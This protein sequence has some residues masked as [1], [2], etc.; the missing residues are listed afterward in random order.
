MVA[1]VPGRIFLSSLVNHSD[2]ISKNILAKTPQ[3]SSAC[4]FIGRIESYAG[5]EKDR[6][7]PPPWQIVIS[8]IF[9]PPAGTVASRCRFNDLTG[10]PTA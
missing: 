6:A 10:K 7:C 3:Q 8:E 1:E 9:H 5:Y 2:P 4:V